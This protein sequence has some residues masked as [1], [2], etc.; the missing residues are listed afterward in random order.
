MPI[1]D[2][3]AGGGGNEGAHEREGD[4]GHGTVCAVVVTYN[5]KEML[6]RCLDTLMRQTEPPARIIVVDN[7]SSDGTAALL[8]AQT[9]PR[10]EHVH[11][12]VNVGAAGG[13]SHGIKLAYR[14]GADFAW[15]MDD[16]VLPEPDALRA[17]LDGYA[18]LR[19][20][21]ITPP[22]L[23]SV[24]RSTTGALT[25]V[26]DIDRRPNRLGFPDWADHLDKGLA[27]VRGATFASIILPR[28]TLREHGAPIAKMFIFGEDR[29]YT[30]RVTQKTPGYMVGTSRVL[31]ARKLEGTLDT[32]R[33][34]DPVRLRYHHYLHRNATAITLRTEPR[35]KVALYLSRQA[36][37]FGGLLVRGRWGRAWL[38]GRAT[39][40]GFVFR[41]SIEPVD[42]ATA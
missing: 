6:S 40:A 31:H 34:V 23:V 37:T 21:G 14:S 17:L 22:F 20:G 3:S 38:I 10:I 9:D 11:L 35:A 30:V 28:A 7:A 24:A 42:A 18:T 1:D 32:R 36:L 13:F 15:A 39:V 5:R 26:P 29:E 27:A 41:P 16:D 25:E 33:E 19:A 4:A 12:P 2:A 8:S